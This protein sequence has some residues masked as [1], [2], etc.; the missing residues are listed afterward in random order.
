MKPKNAVVISINNKAK[1]KI[2]PFSRKSKSRINVRGIDHD[3]SS[4]E[5]TPFGIYDLKSNGTYIYST[6]GSSTADFMV[7]SIKDFW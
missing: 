5:I 4:E 2:G 6:S 7:D 3:F 1:V